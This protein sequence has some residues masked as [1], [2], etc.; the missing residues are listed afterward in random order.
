MRS[1]AVTLISPLP[2]TEIAPAPDLSPAGWLFGEDQARYL[3]TA[4]DPDGILAAAEAAGV[5][6]RA[7]GTVGGDALTVT[8]LG[9]ISVH[10]LK[11]A[12]EAWLPGFMAGDNSS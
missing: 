6:A 1:P 3:V 4:A 7:I 11:S 8:G 5:A 2:L 10:A 12:W 9:A